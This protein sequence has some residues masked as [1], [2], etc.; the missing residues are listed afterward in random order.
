MRLSSR[1]TVVV[2]TVV[3]LAA[4]AGPAAAHQCVNASKNGGAGAQV[5]INFD[6]EIVYMTKGM[7]RR[8]ARGL[9]DLETGEGFHGLLGFDIDGDGR[10]DLATYI[11]G[12][13]GEIPQKAQYNGPACKGVTDIGTWFSECF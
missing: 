5:V 6:D 2:T 11:V 10:A 4:V 13:N 9:V 12:P 8:I 7:E 3:A 1:A